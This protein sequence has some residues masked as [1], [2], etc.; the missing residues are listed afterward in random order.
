MTQRLSINNSFKKGE[1]PMAFKLDDIIVDR[2]Q[3]AY[4]ETTSGDPIGVLT[5]L[6]EATL[7]VSAESTDA[8]DKNGTLIKRFWRGKTGTFTATNAMLNLNVAALMSGT[9]K[10]VA[11]AQNPFENVPGIAIVKIGETA[12]LTGYVDGSAKVNYLFNNG[13]MGDTVATNQYTLV[14]ETGAFTAP[15][16]APVAA[17]DRVVVRYKRDVTAG[18]AIHNSAEQ[19]PDTMVVIL[20]VLIVDPCDASQLRAAYVEL[21]SFQPSPETSISFATDGTIDF[22]GDLQVNYCS[23]DKE[24]QASSVRIAMCA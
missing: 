2:I 8:V 12:T 15:A 22:S 18:V 9:T 3:M 5:Q 1:C 23:S 24:K 19:F 13:T 11:S 14:A 4:L 16:E 10:A 17:V 21:P 7:D 20:K 6:S